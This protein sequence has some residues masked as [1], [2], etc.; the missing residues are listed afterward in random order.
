MQKHWFIKQGPSKQIISTI[1]KE[2]KVSPLMASILHQR[3][4][5]T[6][7]EICSFFNPTLEQLHDPFLMFGMKEAV[8]CLEKHIQNKNK[9]LIYGDYDVDGTTAVAL[10]IEFLKS[11]ADVEYYIPDR[12]TEGYGISFQGVEYAKNAGCNLIIALDCGVREVEKIKHAKELGLDVIVCDHHNP[13]D[14]LPNCIVLDPKQAQC[15]YPYKELCGCGVGFKLLQ[16]W[17][18]FKNE[19]QS[20]L[21]ESL[22]LVAI[23]IGAD[24]VPITGENRVLCSLGLKRLNLQKREGINALIASAKKTYPFSLSD[25]VFTIAPRINAAGRL[26][27]G[28][29]AVELLLSTNKNVA[30]EIALEIDAY[31]TERR[32]LD[33]ETTA[34]AY[35]LITSDA[36]FETQKSTVVYN[37]NW[38]KGVVGIVASRLIE[39]KYRPTIVL[40]ESNGVATGS[41]R[42]VASFNI[43]N[44]IESCTELLTQFGGH[45]HA[46]GLSLPLENIEAFKIQFDTYVQQHI[47]PIDEYEELVIDLEIKLH[48]LFLAGES[49]FQVPRLYN[50]IKELEP[51]GPCNDKPVFCARNVYA[52]N[53]QVLKDFHLRF[54]LIDPSSGVKLQAIGFNMAEKFNIIASGCAF[55]CAFTLETNTWNDKTTLQVQ[56]RDIQEPGLM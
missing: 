40:T 17:L 25:I 54:A 3:G 55:D 13:G 19:D 18:Q 50:M 38:H 27:S 30:N 21:Y 42:S 12:H 10:I 33:A 32:E 44:A 2:L 29:R 11:Y 45:H 34:E 7:A 15:T 43:Y 39:K 1:E 26:S 8:S 23:A 31:N 22:D 24:I 47:K 56:I 9:I 46:A 52:E 53:Q 51:F 14:E 28:T 49:Q 41:A 6:H 36:N 4:L 37:P 48:E 35:E 20:K 5:T 16:A